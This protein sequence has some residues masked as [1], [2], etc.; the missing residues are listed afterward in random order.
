MF[1]WITHY[2]EAMA[3][4]VVG[5]VGSFWASLKMNSSMVDDV[6]ILKAQ[7]ENAEDRLDKHEETI[8]QMLTSQKVA[9]QQ[10]QHIIETADKTSQTVNQVLTHILREK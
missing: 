9:E 5:A 4:L 2:K 8:N 3:A 1:D 7:A 6:K 10:R